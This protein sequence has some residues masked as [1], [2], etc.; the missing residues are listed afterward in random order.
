MAWRSSVSSSRTPVAKARPIRLRWAGSRWAR[1]LKAAGLLD[2]RP[3]IT[4][5]GVRP[6][7]DPLPDAETSD[8]DE[9]IEPLD[10]GE[11]AAGDG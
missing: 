1:D 7:D 11:D 4:A 10:T 3:A 6:S 8:E 5:Y 9:D 2:T